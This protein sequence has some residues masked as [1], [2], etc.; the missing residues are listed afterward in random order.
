[1]DLLIPTLFSSLTPH[2]STRLPSRVCQIRRGQPT[3]WPWSSPFTLHTSP[4]SLPPLDVAPSCLALFVRST[5]HCVLRNAGL[6]L[7][8]WMWLWVMWM[9]WRLPRR[10][11]SKKKG[12][13]PSALRSWRAPEPRAISQPTHPTQPKVSPMKHN[14]LQ[15]SANPFNTR[16]IYS[17]NRRV[18]S[19]ISPNPTGPLPKTATLQPEQVEQAEV[20]SP[21]AHNAVR[22]DNADIISQM[23]LTTFMNTT[24]TL[25]SPLPRSSQPSCLKFIITRYHHDLYTE[26]APSIHLLHDRHATLS[27]KGMH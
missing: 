24:R 13:C 10:G 11:E 2:P 25:S 9:L 16:F 12:S 15:S 5:A 6:W 3:H 1:M 17:R 4:R 22:N 27:C 19:S 20:D 21:S 26:C 8:S 23:S 14:S 18:G 7:W